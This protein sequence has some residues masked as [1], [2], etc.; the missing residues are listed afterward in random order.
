MAKRQRAFQRLVVIDE[1]AY[2]ALRLWLVQ[3]DMNFS[4]LARTLVYRFMQEN[5]INW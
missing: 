5:N 2:K 4:A 3:H 1:R